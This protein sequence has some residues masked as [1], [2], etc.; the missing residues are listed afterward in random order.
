MEL[1]HLDHS[2]VE[3]HE[4][5]IT[6]RHGDTGWDY[7]LSEGQ[8]V[9]VTDREGEFHDAAVLW[10]EDR[11]DEPDGPIYYLHVG[12]RLPPTE[13][14][15]RLAD[16]DML[17]ENRAMHQLLDLLGALAEEDRKPQG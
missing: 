9:V 14:A 15:Q 6:V 3:L 1:L 4:R 17:P 5:P 10:V 8:H 16:V 12:V 7:V 2:M 13:A 11:D